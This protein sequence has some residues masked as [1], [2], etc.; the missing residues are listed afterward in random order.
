[1]AFILDILTM[2]KLLFSDGTLFC[3]K[4]LTPLGQVSVLRR[5]LKILQPKYWIV[6]V[7]VNAALL[8]G[9]TKVKP[10]M[11]GFSTI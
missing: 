9:E 11:P 1:M 10:S 8:R 3:P 7:E 6:C 5:C 2:F 4:H